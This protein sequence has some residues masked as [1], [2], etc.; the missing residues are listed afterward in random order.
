[1][2]ASPQAASITALVLRDGIGLEPY[3]DP[4][5]SLAA[6]ALEANPFY[7]PALMLPALRDLRRDAR[8]EVVLVF[9]RE[10]VA[11]APPR[12]IGLFP[13]ERVARYRGVPLA[14]LQLWKHLHCFL[15]TPLVHREHASESLAGLFAWLRGASGAPLVELGF[16]AGDGDWARALDA[17]LRETGRHGALADSFERALYRPAADFKS[18]LGEAIPRQKRK[19]IQRLERRLAESGRLE[20][21][22]LS[23]D[24]DPLPWID[25]FLALE[26]SGWKG[27]DGTALAADPE[28]R[29]FFREGA[30]ALAAEGRLWVLGLS[31]EGEWIALKC[32]FLAGRGGFAFKIAYDE[33][34]SRFSP[35]VLLE[36]E[37]ISRLHQRPEIEWMD[38]CAV[39]DHFMA[40]RLWTARRKIETRLIATGAASGRLF[41]RALPHLQRARRILAS[42]ARGKATDSAV[43]ASPRDD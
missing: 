9:L 34:F 12:L 42:F 7:E 14:C 36:I 28:Q 27:R 10:P 18:Y 22:E 16:S 38:S 3:V 24:Q 20:F 32:N 13:L 5:R 40:N 8:V 31:L 26:A 4:W 2:L 15:C 17:F 29:R 11:G 39:A 23:P 35:G 43:A 33:K 21:S 1:V 37:T 30:A 41:V 25:A 6:A 19:E